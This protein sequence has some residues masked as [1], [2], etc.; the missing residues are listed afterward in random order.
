LN[1]EKAKIVEKYEKKYGTLKKNI[2]LHL[3]YMYLLTYD[4]ANVIKVGNGILRNQKPN[5]KTR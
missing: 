5:P 2:N 1:A 3:C 4:Y